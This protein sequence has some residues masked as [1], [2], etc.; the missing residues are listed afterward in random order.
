MAKIVMLLAL[1][2]FAGIVVGSWAP[3]VKMGHIHDWGNWE[4]RTIDIRY[5]DNGWW[6]DGVQDIQ[7]R[8]CRVCGYVQEDDSKLARSVTAFS[9]KSQSLVRVDC[10]TAIA[11]EGP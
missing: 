8:T 6:F 2:F 5:Q 10:A 11:K 4:A 7:R 3:I 1:V 9:G